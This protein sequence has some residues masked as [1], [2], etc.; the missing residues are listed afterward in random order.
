MKL[1]YLNEST[2][3]YLPAGRKELHAACLAAARLRAKRPSISSASAFIEHCQLIMASAP[4][5]SFYIFFVDSANKIIGREYKLSEGLE[6]QTAVYPR[7]IMM[8]AIKR[9]AT[10]IFLAHNHPSGSATPSREDCVMTRA[11]SSAAD[12]LEI[13]LLDHI[14]VA[15]EGYFSFRENGYL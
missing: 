7:K 3:E 6:N 15:G 4:V 13:R 14:I 1:Y 8:E 5:E 2:S 12:I 9:N 11:V 10:G